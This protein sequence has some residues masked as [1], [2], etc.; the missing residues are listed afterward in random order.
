MSRSSVEFQPLPP[1]P[2]KGSGLTIPYRGLSRSPVKSAVARFGSVSSDAQRIP[3]RTYT[4]SVRPLD[5]L[6]VPERTHSRISLTAHVTAPLHVGGGTIEGRVCLVIDDGRF[7][8]RHKSRPRISI[9]RLSVDILGVE[10]SHG[11]QWIFRDL[12]HELIDE[13]YSPP[14]TIVAGPRRNS[15]AFWE[16]IPSTSVLPFRLNLPIN[17][18]PPPYKSTRASIKYVLC[19]T[20]LIRVSYKVS[21]VRTSQEI[22]VLS[23][24][25]RMSSCVFTHLMEKVS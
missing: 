20:L 22:V 7:N 25:D 13:V 2:P 24:H 3:S 9:G 8:T 18:G 23:V 14:S 4:R 1:P 11:K 17:M 19:L 21:F 6:E 5:I 15:D 10:T 12:A 16:V